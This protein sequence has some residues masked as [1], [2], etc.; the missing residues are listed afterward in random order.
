MMAMANISKREQSKKM[1]DCGKLILPQWFL[2]Y[3]SPI[4]EGR[5]MQRIRWGGHVDSWASGLFV[6]FR[7]HIFYLNNFDDEHIK[8]RK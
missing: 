1:H 4:S 2:A 7:I 8:M 3:V 5:G 6:V